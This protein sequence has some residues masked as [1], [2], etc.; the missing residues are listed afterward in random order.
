[1]LEWIE[2]PKRAHLI[3]EI[4]NM[5]NLSEYIKRVRTRA[6]VS[7]QVRTCACVCLCALHARLCT[8]VARASEE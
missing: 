1:M 8:C 3:L 2:T 5:G 6:Y 7:A 4:A